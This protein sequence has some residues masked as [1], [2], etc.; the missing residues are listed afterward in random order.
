MVVPTVGQAAYTT[1][2]RGV[3]YAQK[4]SDRQV[5][6]VPVGIACHRLPDPSAK[7]VPRLKG[8][9]HHDGQRGPAPDGGLRDH[10]RR[11]GDPGGIHGAGGVHIAGEFAGDR[12]YHRGQPV[13]HRLFREPAEQPG[14][15]AKEDTGLPQAAAGEYRGFPAPGAGP[16][17]QPQGHRVQEPDH[18]PDHR[19]PE[20]RGQPAGDG[21]GAPP[22]IPSPEQA[23]RQQADQAVRRGK[24]PPVQ[25]TVLAHGVQRGPGR[26]GVLLHRR[27]RDR[28]DARHPERAVHRPGALGAGGGAAGEHPPDPEQPSTAS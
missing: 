14:D 6:R 13:R 28:P 9:G 7:A 23:G 11:V 3:S 15:H 1:S 10:T 20:D 8:D 17:G 24:Y 5:L 27:L 26:R 18:P 25:H 4:E 2:D 21:N 16:A 19:Q 12:G 22:G